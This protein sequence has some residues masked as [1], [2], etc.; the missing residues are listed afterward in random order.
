M[1]NF[2]ITG[3]DR[4]YSNE[5]GQ[6]LRSIQVLEDEDTNEKYHQSYLNSEFKIPVG[7]QVPCSY[8]DQ[9]DEHGNIVDYIRIDKLMIF[10]KFGNSRG[11]ILI[12]NLFNL[13]CDLEGARQNGWR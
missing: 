12:D 5:F 9:K 13:W 7:Y 11:E 6:E 10:D 1:R 8:Y 2:W 4:F 3:S